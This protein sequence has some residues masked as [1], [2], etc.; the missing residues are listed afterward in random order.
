MTKEEFCKEQISKITGDNQL[1]KI[2]YRDTKTVDLMDEFEDSKKTYLKLFHTFKY[3]IFYDINLIIAQVPREKTYVIYDDQPTITELKSCIGKRLSDCKI[4]KRMR[5]MAKII[6]KTLENEPV[7]EYKNIPLI[8]PCLLGAQSSANRTDYGCEWIG[9]GDWIEKTMFG[10]VTD[11]LVV[12][13]SLCKSRW[14]EKH[15]Y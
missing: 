5:Y 7:V 14:A 13:V 2:L 11:Y 10:E 4:P 3:D 6:A 15:G 9:G 8:E 1:V 12:G